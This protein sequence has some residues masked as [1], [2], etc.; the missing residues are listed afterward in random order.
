M[1]RFQAALKK[2][3][4][5]EEEIFQTADLFEKRNIPQV[6]LCLYALARLVSDCD[7][8]Y[9]VLHRYFMTSKVIRLLCRWVEKILNNFM[10][11]FESTATLF[12]RIIFSLDQKKHHT[13]K[14]FAPTSSPPHKKQLNLYFWQ[15]RLHVLLVCFPWK[16]KFFRRIWKAS[17]ILRFY[18]IISIGWYEKW[19]QGKGRYHE[20]LFL[21]NVSLQNK[22][23]V[24]RGMPK[25]LPIRIRFVKWSGPKIEKKKNEFWTK[26]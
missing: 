15:S 5:P 2:Y 7:R 24:T 17:G 22:Y 8:V 6:T 23:F 3:G 11:H 25:F 26:F 10:N 14:P 16:I 20:V 21:V 4:V 13:P 12:Y 9:D 18:L 1:I 19:W